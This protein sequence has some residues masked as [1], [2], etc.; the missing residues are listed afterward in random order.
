MT[1]KTYSKEGIGIKYPA[2]LVFVD[3]NWEHL[4]FAVTPPGN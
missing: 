1:G 4:G 2:L 3:V